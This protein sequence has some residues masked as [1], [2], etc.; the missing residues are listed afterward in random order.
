M[1]GFEN[2]DLRAWLVEGLTR[3]VTPRKAHHRQRVRRSGVQAPAIAAATVAAIIGGV[4]ATSMQLTMPNM[5]SAGTREV[6]FE[7]APDLQATEYWKN[8]REEVRGWKTLE[9]ND[10]IDPPEL[11]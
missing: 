5:N 9:E 11:I 4:G 10:A 1:I 8:L 6:V 3:H 2:Y 7:H